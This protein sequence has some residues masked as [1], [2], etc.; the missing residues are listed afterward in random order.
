M[1]PT[2]PSRRGFV[3]TSALAPLLAALP[4]WV[5]AG[6]ARI[7]AGAPALWYDQPAGPW[8]EALPVGNGRLG[9]MVF[10]RPAQERLQFNID[11]L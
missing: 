9:A 6:A 8:V 1:N 2:H 10:G 7:E 11:T 4:Q 3:A 5:R